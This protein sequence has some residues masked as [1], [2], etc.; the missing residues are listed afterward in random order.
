M[1]GPSVS[2]KEVIRPRS[3]DG[4]AVPISYIDGIVTVTCRLGGQD[5]KDTIRVPLHAV[6]PL[7]LDWLCDV[8][9]GLSASS[10][11]NKAFTGARF[12]SYLVESGTTNLGPEDFHHFLTWL[13]ELP[14]NRGTALAEATRRRFAGDLVSFFAW[15]SEESD[16]I[17][18]ADFEAIENRY[19]RAFRGFTERQLRRLRDSSEAV[20]SD[21]L[22]RLYTA[23]RWK[24]EWVE[25][26][27]D[28]GDYQALLADKAGPLIPFVLLMGLGQA[29]RSG[30]INNLKLRDI[31]RKDEI[32]CVHQ[33][34]KRPAFLPLLPEAMR[35]LRAIDRWYATFRSDLDDPEAPA[36]VYC[37]WRAGEPKTV[38]LNSRR[39]KEQLK[40]FYE[41]AF[42]HRTPVGDPVLFALDERGQQGPFRL[43][44][45]EYRHAAITEYCRNESDIRLL[46]IFARHEWYST[47]E[48]YQR[49]TSDETRNG[50]SEGL[51][52]YAERLRLRV[53]ARQATE[54]Q[55]E[56]A[57]SAGAELPGGV[58]GEVLNGAKSCRRAVDCRVC[59]RFLI[60]PRKRSWFENDTIQRQRRIA[61]VSERGANT[62]DVQNEISLLALNEAILQAID[63]WTR[64]EAPR[65]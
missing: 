1:T 15:L 2:R 52:P 40:Q 61:Q 35:A 5:V 28:A 21:D 62:R 39:M 46:R 33:L 11:R 27:L 7:I 6:R 18:M 20:S 26:Q 19:R 32:V 47:T 14:T 60:D 3:S 37:L 43:P 51:K 53:S 63:E 8:T 24:L 48:R 44:F 34:N 30:E 42:R 54:Q 50:I 13:K 22:K 31:N 56:A 23:I 9:P 17:S 49:F 59:E 36:L 57:S 4:R 25:E 29:M 12:V 55:I 10:V 64:P 38:Q 16:L 45:H 41:Q 65:E 58:C